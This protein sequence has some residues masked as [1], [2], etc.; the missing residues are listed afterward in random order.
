MLGRDT[1][2]EYSYQCLSCEDHFVSDESHMGQ[3]SCPDCGSSDVRS[4]VTEP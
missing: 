2:T 4:V 1:S 3:V